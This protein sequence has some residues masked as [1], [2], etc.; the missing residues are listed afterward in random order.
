MYVTLLGASG[1]AIIM[2][3]FRCKKLLLVNLSKKAIWNGFSF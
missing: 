2:L 3:L 1:M